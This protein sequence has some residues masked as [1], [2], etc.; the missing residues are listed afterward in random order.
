MKNY[1]R[2]ELIAFGKNCFYKGFDKGFDKA[3]NY[4]VNCFT[5]W[6][7]EIE[8]LLSNLYSEEC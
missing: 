2:D 5:A 7:E 1:T 3:E 8:N 6:R 4:D